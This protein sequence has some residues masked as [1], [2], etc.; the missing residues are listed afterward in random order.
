[1]KY[2]SGVISSELKI[3]VRCK[4]HVSYFSSVYLHHIETDLYTR[5]QLKCDDFILSFLSFRSF[6]DCQT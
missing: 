5:K 6:D 1:M 3:F 2:L 4:K